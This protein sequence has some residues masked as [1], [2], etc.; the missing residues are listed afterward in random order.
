MAYDVYIRRNSDGLVRVYHEDDP[1]TWN[2]ST[3]FMWSE[4]NYGCDCNRYL[5]FQRAA[6]E[7]EDDDVSCG[8]T[9]YFCIKVRLPDGTEIPMDNEDEDR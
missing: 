9:Q 1:Y 7:N 8:T 3:E 4:G 2:D 6:E 5:F